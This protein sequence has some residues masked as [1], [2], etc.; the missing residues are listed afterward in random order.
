MSAYHS[1]KKR[2]HLYL[3]HPFLSRA[4]LR[5]CARKPCS[6]LRGLCALG[7]RRNITRLNT[8]AK[9]P[10]PS[11]PSQGKI[12]SIL[13]ILSKNPLSPPPPKKTLRPLWLKTLFSATLRLCARQ[14][15]G[16]PPFSR[17]WAKYGG[18]RGR[19]PS[20]PIR[21][22]SLCL[23]VFARGKNGLSPFPE[24]GRHAA[25]RGDARPPSKFVALLWASAS[26]REKTLFK[27]SR[28]LRT[29]RETFPKRTRP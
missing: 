2:F 11:A 7:V 29:W 1:I 14:K 21:C 26:L 27:T 12:L 16:L 22:S 24:A 3:P 13:L 6:K 18:S 20:L 25:A 8:A 19:S 28:A 10:R 17:D 5:L 15:N 4:S 23:C 9:E